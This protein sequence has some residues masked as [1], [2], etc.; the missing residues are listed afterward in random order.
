MDKDVKALGERNWK[1]IARNREIW[2]KLLRKAMAQKRAVM[3]MMMM[4]IRTEP[5]NRY[6]GMSG[7]Y[8][9]VYVVLVKPGFSF[10]TVHRTRQTT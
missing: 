2:Q 7:M 6:A 4:I 3:P 5:S 9:E 10:Q 8:P 1:N